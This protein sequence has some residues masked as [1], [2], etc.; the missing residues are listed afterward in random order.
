MESV[1]NEER[2][3]QFYNLCHDI[4]TPLAAIMGMT[5]LTWSELEDRE[6]VKDR[7]AGIE[8]TSNYLLSIVSGPQ[9][10]PQVAL[11]HCP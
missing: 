10:C 1:V 7:L 6:K 8:I 3:T 2:V 4:K 9:L 5:E 11:W